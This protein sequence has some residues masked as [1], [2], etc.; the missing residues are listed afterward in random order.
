MP[1]LPIRSRR[2][3]SFHGDPRQF[4]QVCSLTNVGCQNFQI[5]PTQWIDQEY[6]IRHPQRSAGK[7]ERPHRVD[8]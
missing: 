4:G 2:Q 6:L 7:P 3:A 8:Y 1:F 5:L